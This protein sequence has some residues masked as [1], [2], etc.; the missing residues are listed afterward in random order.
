MQDDRTSDMIEY[1]TFMK[2]N[3]KNIMTNFQ[4]GVDN[5]CFNWDIHRRNVSNINNVRFK[6]RKNYENIFNNSNSI[7]PNVEKIYMLQ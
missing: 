3:V 7:E 4:L 6:L 1:L 2:E 5:Q